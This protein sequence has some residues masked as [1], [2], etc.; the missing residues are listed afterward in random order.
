M[1]SIR[2]RL[3]VSVDGHFE[4]ASMLPIY[5]LSLSLSAGMC[6]ST[7]IFVFKWKQIWRDAGHGTMFMMFACLC[8]WSLM[9][10]ARVFVVFCNYSFWD[11]LEDE[12]LLAIS[13][14]TEMLFNA[15]SMWF[16]LAV[17]ELYRR[18]VRP[19]SS[20]QSQRALKWY[21]GIIY[22]IGLAFVTAMALLCYEGVR[23]LAEDG[24]M[25]L[26]ASWILSYM[27]W[28]T[29]GI[30][31]LSLIYGASVATSMY[32]QRHHIQLARLPINVLVIVGLFVLLNLPY[33]IMAPV[34]EYE[35]VSHIRVVEWP[36][37]L[38]LLRAC[39]HSSGAIISVL[40]G[41]SIKGFD[42]F[43]LPPVA[44]PKDSVQEGPPSFFFI[45]DSTSRSSCQLQ[46]K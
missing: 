45:P 43:Y 10:L 21:I 26:I 12:T 17:Y 34:S 37:L 38:K 19:R 3:Q 5:V 46:L 42:A 8:L 27:T 22:T 28:G 7:C 35:S 44:P 9:T 30:R 11:N 40:M 32:C 23:F 29:W 2:R 13:I 14:G 31:L 15:I 20:E 25:D 24:E 41:V 6:L 39:T 16:A 18:A 33:L 4:S 1:P 36:F